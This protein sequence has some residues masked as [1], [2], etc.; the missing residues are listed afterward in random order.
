MLRREVTRPLLRPAGRAVLAGL[1][2]LVLGRSPRTLLRPV[3]DPPRLAPRFGGTAMDALAPAVGPTGAGGGHCLNGPSPGQREPDLGISPEECKPANQTVLTIEAD[4][5]GAAGQR[6]NRED[7]HPSARTDGA[8][9]GPASRLGLAGVLLEVVEQ[10][11]QAG[12]G[13]ADD[14]CRRRRSKGAGC[15]R[16]RA[17]PTRRRRR[18]RARRHPARRARAARRPI[19]CPAPASWWG[20]R[21]R[22]GPGRAGRSIPTR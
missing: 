7:V 18:R 3:R 1:S 11:R 4:I 9:E 13:D 10:G 17:A 12:L 21:G 8:H 14:G 5:R 6:P 16:R 2:R 15:R 20:R 22:A 19:H